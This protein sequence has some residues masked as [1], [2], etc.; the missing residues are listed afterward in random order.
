MSKSVSEPVI[1]RRMLFSY[2]SIFRH[3]AA[4]IEARFRNSAHRI[5]LLEGKELTVSELPRAAPHRK[6]H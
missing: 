3:T 2:G 6:V 4:G 5:R 1:E